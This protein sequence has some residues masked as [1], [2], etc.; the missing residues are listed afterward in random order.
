MTGPRGREGREPGR[1]R[2]LFGVLA[3]PAAWLFHLVTSFA[4]VD[5]ACSGG[6]AWILHL[7]T[8]L[9]LGL[10]GSA[11]A[12]ALRARSRAGRASVVDASSDTPGGGNDADAPGFPGWAR[13]LVATGVGFG[14]GFSGLILLA[15]IPALVLNP[16]LP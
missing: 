13:F 12:V 5:R 9:A 16:C 2:L 3:P 14:I 6:D 15:G 8:L 7:V 1:G 10:S 4:L 11:L